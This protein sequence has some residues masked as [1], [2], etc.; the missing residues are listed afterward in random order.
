MLIALHLLAIDEGLLTAAVRA[1]EMRLTGELRA[2]RLHLN[3]RL[4]VFELQSWLADGVAAE[5][6]RHLRSSKRSIDCLI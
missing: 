3:V 1:V 2:L 4:L 6:R 5:L